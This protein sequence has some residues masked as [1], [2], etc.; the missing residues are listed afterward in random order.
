MQCAYRIWPTRTYTGPWLFLAKQPSQ[1]KR[2]NSAIR[3]V[4]GF[5]SYYGAGGLA[6]IPPIAATRP[7]WIGLAR[8]TKRLDVVS[9]HLA[10]SARILNDSDLLEAWQRAAY[11]SGS[12]VLGHRRALHYLHPS[13]VACQEA[14]E[15]ADPLLRGSVLYMWVGKSRSCGIRP[16]MA[17][18]GRAEYFAITLRDQIGDRIGR[19]STLVTV[20]RKLANAY[21]CFRKK[22]A[23]ETHAQW[24]RFKMFP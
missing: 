22:H 8:K 24:P 17:P 14:G 23:C 10:S 19:E 13:M 2:C 20:R 6:T 16:S 1:R 4:P 5:Y 11:Q 3:G 7:S 12:H 9:L 18:K 15:I 21:G